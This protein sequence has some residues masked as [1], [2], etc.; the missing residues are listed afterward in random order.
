MAKNCVPVCVE[1][2]IVFTVDYDMNTSKPQGDIFDPRN[3]HIAV[4]LPRS[5][6]ITYHKLNQN[7]D[8][9]KVIFSVVTTVPDSSW[10][11]GT[12]A[13]FKEHDCDGPDGVAGG[14]AVISKV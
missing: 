13:G 10:T 2:K 8:D 11:K 12:P 1:T 7:I 3:I 9:N 6:S 14:L 5:G 4:K